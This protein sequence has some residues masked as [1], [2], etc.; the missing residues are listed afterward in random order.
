ML[1]GQRASDSKNNSYYC[2]NREQ[3]ILNS[4]NRVYNQL[5]KYYLNPIFELE[6]DDASEEL[7]FS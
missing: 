4:G 5:Q 3:G 6:S 1:T 2:P 7:A